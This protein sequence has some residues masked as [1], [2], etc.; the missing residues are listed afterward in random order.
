MNH[1][2]Y[3]GKNIKIICTDG[4]ILKGYCCGYDLAINDDEL[5][6][7]EIC[8]KEGNRRSEICIGISEIKSIEV[9]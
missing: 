7:N 4:Q 5:K 6:E 1:E 3:V 2:D 8:I 9:I